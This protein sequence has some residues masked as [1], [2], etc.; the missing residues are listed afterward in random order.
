LTEKD[1][2][3]GLA[4]GGKK[5]P[6][7]EA[8]ARKK[9]Q[10]VDRS[11]ARTALGSAVPRIPSIAHPERREACARD[12]VLFCGTYFPNSTGL[13]PM[14][15]D[16]VGMY[17][18]LEAAAIDGGQFVNAFPRGFGKSTSVEN[19]CLWAVLNA[20]VR[21]VALL[22]AE[23]PLSTDSLDS[24]K[25]EL[26][27]ND[28]L[29]EDYPEVVYPLRALEGTPQRCQRQT[30]E[31]V[32]TNS[33]W[34]KDVI[35][36]PT[37]A[38]SAASGAIIKCKGITGSVLGLRHKDGEGNQI[39]PDLIVADDIET[40]ESAEQPGQVRKRL[41]ILIKSI[42]GLGGHD[43]SLAVVVNG[44]ILSNGSAIHQLLDPKLYPAWQGK[45]VKMLIKPADAQDEFWLGKYRETRH[46]FNPE[47]AEDRK[48]AIR[49]ANAL[50]LESRD[51]A[52]AGAVVSWEHCYSRKDE[53]SAI[54]HAY[55]LLIDRGRDYFA[56]ECQNEPLV[57]ENRSAAVTPADVREHVISAKAWIM[58]TG[59]TTLTAFVDV[60][61]D[62]LYWLVSA[63]GPGLRGHVVGY[64]A[65][66]EQGRNY[67]TLRD[68]G[69]TLVDAAGGASLESAIQQGL[70]A[71]CRMLLDREV[72][73]EWDDAT[74]RLSLLLIDANWQQSQNVVRE[75]VRRSPWGTRVMPSN[76]RYVG[77]A[78]RTL[79]DRTPPPGERQGAH[80][81]TNTLEKVRHLQWDTNT[82]KTMVA[83]RL[84]LPDG[85]PNRITIHGGKPHDL[86]EDHFSS[87]YPTRAISK[88]RAAD[89]WTQIP[90]RDDHLWDCLVG[91]AAGASFV[92]IEAVGA[93]IM[94]RHRAQKVVTSEE[95]AARAAELAA[96]MR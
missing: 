34:R 82:W 56:T 67:F 88:E 12:P 21:Y 16:H 68:C 96:M 85:D 64:G 44:T 9:A 95:L 76:G 57:D 31:G 94:D 22:A 15:S 10:D 66:P 80:W 79:T 77:V 86:I 84:K 13:Y 93:T 61:K 2:I 23:K 59:T 37:I 89:L 20:I 83:G 39:R 41:N 51:L 78:G 18:I 62:L 81:R 74:S 50:Y 17:R 87:Q 25:R 27:E 38:G 1:R 55:N 4:A 46:S 14:S 26:L 43:K 36:L 35:V 53:L 69:R 90:G 3:A 42:L 45:R 28:L 29:A 71:V 11:R 5:G 24:I 7:A 91:S 6:D 58:P 75:F 8:A 19:F 92:G 52:D 63:W 47:D 33:L 40:R 54:Q 32:P 60:Q 30:Y 72:G 49:E 73:H 48:R 70:D 65:Y